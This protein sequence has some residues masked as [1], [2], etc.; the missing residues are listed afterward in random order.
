MARQDNY[1]SRKE[2]VILV[3]D[4]LAVNQGDNI[5]VEARKRVSISAKRL[6]SDQVDK[7]RGAA[8][9]TLQVHAAKKTCA[10]VIKEGYKL[11]QSG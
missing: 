8:R 1:Y 3:P 11:V 10:G 7:T 2:P 6:D 5:I 4:P 9:N